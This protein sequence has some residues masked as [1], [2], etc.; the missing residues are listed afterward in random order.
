MNLNLEGKKVLITGASRG[1]GA[2]IAYRFLEEGSDVVIVSRG[3]DALLKT[4][5]CIKLVNH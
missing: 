2:S 3:S 5:K 1:I 4:E